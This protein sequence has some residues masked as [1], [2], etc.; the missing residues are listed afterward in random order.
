LWHRLHSIKSSPKGVSFHLAADDGPTSNR[1]ELLAAINALMIRVWTDEGFARIAI[2]TDSEYVVVN[3]CS[4][5]RVGI[6]SRETV[7][8]RQK[9]LL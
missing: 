5:G 9:E 7:A 2:A 1:A 4:L 6:G 8:L 3:M